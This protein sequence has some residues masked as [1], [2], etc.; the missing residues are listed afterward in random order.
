M[1]KAKEGKLL[2]EGGPGALAIGAA[3]IGAIAVGAF[4]KRAEPGNGKLRPGPSKRP[5]KRRRDSSFS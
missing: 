2:H 4:V 1:K 3:A 5:Q